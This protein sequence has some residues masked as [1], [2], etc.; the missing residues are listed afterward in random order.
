MACKV[1]REW[2]ATTEAQWNNRQANIATRPGASF[3]PCHVCGQ[4]DWAT[5]KDYIIIY[6]PPPPRFQRWHSFWR[7]LWP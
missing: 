1:C 4:M 6:D 2:A 5:T 7:A 3:Y